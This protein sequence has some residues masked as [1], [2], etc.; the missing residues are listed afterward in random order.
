MDAEDP[1]ERARRRAA[2]AGRRADELRIKRQAVDSGDRPSG[3]TAADVE[4]ATLRA[5]TAVTR[6]AAAYESS[7]A[8]H[9]RAAAEHDRSARQSGDPDGTHVRA[10]AVHRDAAAYDRAEAAALPAPDAGAPPAV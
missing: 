1:G 10:A 5:R 2:S 9:D 8:A 6:L 3:S 7:A 4:T